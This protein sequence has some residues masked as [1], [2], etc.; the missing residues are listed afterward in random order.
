MS[1]RSI[2]LILLLVPLI[3]FASILSDAVLQQQFFKGSQ[4]YNEQRYSESIDAFEMLIENGY[5]NKAVYYNLG[6]AYFRDG[7]AGH[8]VVNYRRAWFFDPTDPDVTANMTHAIKSAKSMRAE[9]GMIT[10]SLTRLSMEDWRNMSM[11]SVWGVAILIGL[12]L[13]FSYRRFFIFGIVVAMIFSITS[14]SGIG[15][16]KQIMSSNEVVIVDKNVTARYAPLKEGKEFYNITEGTIAKL[17][18]TKEGWVKIDFDGQ[19]G[20]VERKVCEQVWNLN[21]G[22]TIK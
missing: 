17:V 6:N 10:E 12:S 21:F 3:S 15:V 2:V 22:D 9:Q 5:G 11:L 18:S 16:W 1:K 4:A 8:A 19:K 13:F 20:W 14:F 7:K